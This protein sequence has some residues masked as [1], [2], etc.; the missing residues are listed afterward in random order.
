[1]FKGKAS[2][3]FVEAKGKTN[4]SH[5]NRE[6]TEE[7]KKNKAHEHIDWN[8]T[9]ENI[10]IVKKPIEKYFNEIFS[11]AVNEYN[12]KQKRKDRQVGNYYKKVKKDGLLETQREFI[13]QLGDKYIANDSPTAR[14]EFSQQLQKYEKWFEKEFPN[15]KVYNAV[16]HMD[17]ATPHLHLNV[18]PVATGYTRGM[19]K[20]SSFS[21]WIENNI[22]FDEFRQ[23]NIEK[24]ESLLNEIDYERNITEV[25]HEHLEPAQY[26]ELMKKAE[27]VLSSANEQAEKIKHEKTIWETFKKNSIN[28]FLAITKSE[29]WNYIPEKIK[30]PFGK[31]TGFLK[32]SEKMWHGLKIAVADTFKKNTDLEKKN[33]D[34]EN[35]NKILNEQIQNQK[36]MK[37]QS[38][39]AAE[40]YLKL[41][42]EK[43]ELEKG[44]KKEQANARINNVAWQLIQEDNPKFLDIKKKYIVSAMK[45]I[46]AQNE[47]AN[48]LSR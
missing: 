2:I 35:Q 6:L 38:R 10:S 46:Q 47:Q 32:I 9:E 12:L 17:E 13:V 28:G 29:F 39:L 24:L 23:K 43:T 44:L 1:M 48:T 40:Q 20:R 15:L 27:N 25:K 8:R 31:E 3:S 19:P 11:D 14:K 37:E 7:R 21:K 36:K 18:I 33:T 4:I 16:I 45:K 5:N 42:K 41:I 30:N 34:L 22:S 26:R